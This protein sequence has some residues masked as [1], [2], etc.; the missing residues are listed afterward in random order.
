MRTP[1]PDPSTSFIAPLAR[2]DVRDI[3]LPRALRHI[4]RSRPPAAPGPALPCAFAI[5]HPLVDRRAEKSAL[6][7]TSVVTDLTGRDG[8]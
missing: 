5:F 7:R 1:D 8:R 2:V 3:D 4:R 6:A